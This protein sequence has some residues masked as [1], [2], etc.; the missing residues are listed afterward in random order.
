MAVFTLAPYCL[1]AVRLGSFTLGLTFVCRL[2][3]SPVRG[4]A[5]YGSSVCVGG[6]CVTR[7]PGPSI[8]ADAVFVLGRAPYCLFCCEIG[9]FYFRSYC[10]CRS[11]KPQWGALLLYG[12]SVCVGGWCVTRWPG[13]S[14]CADAVFVLGRAPY[15]LFAVRLG[16][17]ASS[18]TVVCR[19]L[20]P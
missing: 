19:S 20:K 8:C 9:F 6:W 16:S 3:E 12:Y 7:W 17:F 18:L 1:F 10:C 5:D 4:T 13:P 14:I 15:C 11:L 2:M